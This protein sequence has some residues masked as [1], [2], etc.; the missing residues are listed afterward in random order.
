LSIWK[1]P[2]QLQE[3]FNRRLADISSMVEQVQ[4]KFPES[5]GNLVKD[6]VLV[7]TIGISPAESGCY[8]SLTVVLI[9]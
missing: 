9:Q 4:A 2:R 7:S 8:S 3:Q 6:I 1:G 5:F